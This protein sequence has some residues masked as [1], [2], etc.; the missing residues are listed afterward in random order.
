M[1]WFL[2]VSSFLALRV[3]RRENDQDRAGLSDKK[4]RG[5]NKWRG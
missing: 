2:L 1:P 4:S 5:L 3:H